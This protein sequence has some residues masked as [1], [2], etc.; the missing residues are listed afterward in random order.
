VPRSPTDERLQAQLEYLR[1]DDRIRELARLAAEMTPEERLEQ[2]WSMS[3]SAA[4]MLDN[5]PSEVRERLEAHRQP[6][7]PDSEEAL[8]RL[9]RLS[10]AGAPGAADP[11]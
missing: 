10:I 3:R 9:A 7:T 11:D 5:L 6:L 4:A 8:R 1:S 2:A